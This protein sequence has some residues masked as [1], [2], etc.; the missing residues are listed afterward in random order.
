[1]KDLLRRMEK[2]QWPDTATELF[3]MSMP[4]VH[5]ISPFLV[6]IYDNRVIH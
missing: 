3:V 4:I 1:M 6:C 2:E 5:K